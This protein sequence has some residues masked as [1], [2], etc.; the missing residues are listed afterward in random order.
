MKMLQ[1]LQNILATLG[2]REDAKYTAV[3]EKRLEYLKT[4][5]YQV[6]YPQFKARQL[7]PVSNEADPGAETITYEQWDDFGMAQ[8]IANYADDLPLVD[9]LAEDYTT[10]VKGIGAA[11]Q[12]SIQDLK[13]SVMSGANLP[14]KKARAARRFIEQ[15]IEDI[16]ALGESAYG[17]TGF[18][19]NANVALTTPTTGTWS[20]ATAAQIIAD[21]DKLV[22]AIV[23]L[24]KETYPPTTIAMDVSL[25]NIIAH[26]RVSTTGDTS[27]T[28]LEDY[29]AS[30]PYITEIVSW[31][32][33]ATADAAGTGPR[34]VAYSK[35]PDVMSLEIP[36]EF[37][38]F[39][40]QAKNLSFV[41]PTH[42][43]CAGVIM[44]LPMAV[45]YM[46]GC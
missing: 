46:D 2:W 5:V 38:Q 24:T 1:Y 15:K 43:R 32:K 29:I 28:V 23:V 4:K 39:P 31:N 27:R 22:S 37:E 20:G 7:I 9:A 3:L 18:A 35:D 14:E 40:P 30:S 16:A 8:I 44:P 19:N 10:K 11:Y 13:R 36:Q 34:I 12:Y 41:I 25:Y 17:L 6:M 21:L 26:K 33:L 45:G 42:A